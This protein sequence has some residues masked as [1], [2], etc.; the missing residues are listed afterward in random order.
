MSDPTTSTLSPLDQ[1]ALL[2]EAAQVQRRNAELALGAYSQFMNNKTTKELTPVLGQTP[3]DEM[4]NL[5]GASVTR[6]NAINKKIDKL[7][8]LDGDDL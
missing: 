2:S 4:L 1:M 3:R 5:L 6:L 7:I 8:G